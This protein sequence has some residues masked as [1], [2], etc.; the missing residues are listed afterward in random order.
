MSRLLTFDLISLPIIAIISIPLGI[1]AILT[2]SV[3][4]TILAIR[5][6][7]IYFELLLALLQSSLHF[8]STSSRSSSSSSTKDNTTITPKEP[9]AL[10][11][12]S[13]I[14]EA[15]RA[16][17]RRSSEASS[18]A[19]SFV[20][21]TSG[22]TTGIHN[23]NSQGAAAASIYSPDHFHKTSSF[24]SLIG[25]G[26]TRDYEGVG[27]WRISNNEE[28][29]ALWMGMNS[30]LELPAVF[31]TSITSS[32]SALSSPELSRAS[33]THRR[34]FTGSGSHYQQQYGQQ[35]RYTFPH[36]N[37][38][39]GGGGEGGGGGV[40]PGITIRT[41][42]ATRNLAHHNY[43]RHHQNSSSGSG[44]ASPESY[45]NF[46]GGGG[47]SAAAAA[48]GRRESVAGLVSE[49]SRSE[50]PVASRVSF[51]SGSRLLSALS[52]ARNGD[53]GDG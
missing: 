41:P 25:T 29:D 48:A 28:D 6:S 26:T 17:Q 16:R 40:S 39:G 27:G 7:V 38:T 10:P 14:R 45:F 49:S 47:H 11:P 9:I 30:Q 37:D 31:P 34:S 12:S 1:F 21:T 3:A 23:G 44:T 24:A 32:S 51:E 5:V 19:P 50:S 52:G 43:Q 42:F 46:G 36:G 2:S 20:T 35:Q 8:K 53:L 15:A 33:K 22:G 4:F 18:I 13:P